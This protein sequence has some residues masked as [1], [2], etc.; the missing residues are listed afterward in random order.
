MPQKIAT[1]SQPPSAPLS[2]QR[3]ILAAYGLA[4]YGKSLFWYVSELF[5]AFYLTEM[6][7]L[8]PQRMALVLGLGLVVSAAI[9]GLIGWRFGRFMRDPAAA[10]RLQF[11]GAALSAAALILVFLA[12]ALPMDFRFAYAIV[13][14]L[15]FRVAYASY[16]LP[17]NAL[18][19]LRDWPGL[20]RGGVTALRLIGSAL[21]ML[22]VGA[23]IAVAFAGGAGRSQDGRI[24]W[25][26]AA[27]AVVAV[28][29]ALGLRL[30]LRAEPARDPPQVRRGAIAWRPLLLPIGLVFVISAA[31]SAFTKLEPFFGVHALGSAAWGARIAVAFSLGSLLSQPVWAILYARL[32]RRTFLGLLGLA[33]ALAA[34]SFMALA[35]CSPLAALT[36]GF[37]L[38]AL[39]GGFGLLLW[40]WFADEAALG[41]RGAESLAFAAFTAASKLSLAAAGVYVGLALAALDYRGQQSANL[42]TAM[43]FLALLAGG[44]VLAAALRLSRLPPDSS[45]V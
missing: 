11:V 28:V 26:I 41:A 44:V 27:L 3:W 38:G 14:G 1:R 21:A 39:N 32:S 17:Q 42:S 24:A 22:T 23:A 30:A 2:R 15:A 33:L 7:G 12:D 4:H 45:P 37:G 35:A 19:S 25:V 16:D 6:A 5:F 18:L 36:L 20:G 34:A 43:S 10:G 29:S 31:F 9:D 8:P 40:S 13:I